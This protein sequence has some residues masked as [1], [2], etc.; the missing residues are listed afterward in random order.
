[1]LPLLSMAKAKKTIDRSVLVMIEKQQ[2]CNF[3][4]MLAFDRVINRKGVV[5]N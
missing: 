1:M 5:G 4:Y 2:L 3:D